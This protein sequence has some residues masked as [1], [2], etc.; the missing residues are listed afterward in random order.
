MTINTNL[1]YKFRIIENNKII[2]EETPLIKNPLKE[3]EVHGSTIVSLISPGT[4]LAVLKNASGQF[5]FP[6]GLGYACVFE[7]EEIGASVSNIKIGDRVFFS[8]AH[9]SKQTALEQDV[10]K[11]PKDLDSKIA[12][13][14]RL[15][16]VSMSTLTTTKARPPQTVVVTGLGLVGHLATQIFASCGYQVFGIDPSIEKRNLAEKVGLKNIYKDFSYLK[17]NYKGKVSLVVECS[18]HEDAVKDAC[19][20]VRKGGEVVMVG[21]PWSK[22]SNLSAFDLLSLIFH[23]YVV[24]RSGWEWEVPKQNQ[25]FVEGSLI[26]NYAGAISWL[27]ENKI[28]VSELAESKNPENPQQIYDDIINQKIKGLSCL[29]DWKNKL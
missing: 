6:T 26:G 11:L 16:G 4:E 20:I 2:L 19:Q 27:A 24:L 13:Y 10:V 15:M 18:G 21:V 7:V 5:K 3:K 29:I 12:V 28:N 17:E 1:E 9:K 14:A 25:D 22:Q 23:N 8:G